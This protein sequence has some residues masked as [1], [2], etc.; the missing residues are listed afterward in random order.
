MVTSHRSA[1]D[2]ISLNSDPF[3]SHGHMHHVRRALISLWMISATLSGCIEDPPSLERDPAGMEISDQT[4]LAGGAEMSQGRDVEG[5]QSLIVDMATRDED[6]E[7]DR[8]RG[9]DEVIVDMASVSPDIDVI[10]LDLGVDAGSVVEEWPALD[11]PL[12]EAEEERCD[13]IDNDLDALIDEGVSNPCGG[14]APFDDEVGCVAWRAQLIQTQ[15]RVDGSSVEPSEE[16]VTGALDPQRLIMLSTSI[17]RFEEFTVEGARCTRYGAAQSWSGARSFGDVS[18]NTPQASLTLRPDPTQPGRYRALGEDEPFTLHLPQDEVNLSWSGWSNPQSA[19]PQP[20]I[21]PDELSLRSPELIRLADDDELRQIVEAFQRAEDPLAAPE[22][23]SLRWVAEPQGQE[24]G[25]PLTLYVG[26]SQSLRRAGAYQEIRHYLLSAQLFDDGRLDLDL[27]SSF[28]A[29]GSSIW[30]YLERAHQASAVQGPH[31]VTARAGHRA[32]LRSGAGGGAPN[33][34]VA[35]ELLTPGVDRPEP[36]VGAEGLT[37]RWRLIDAAAPPE[38]IVISLI[39]YDSLRTE[40]IA[41]RVDDPSV[42]TITLP[43]DRLNFWPQGPQS[44]RQ[45]TLRADTKS[46][47]LSYPDRGL[48][49]RSESLILRLSDLD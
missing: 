28:R 49:R 26:G 42:G 25:A 7:L 37:V 36:D 21:E 15:I 11:L 44:V 14:C 2:H 20:I 35:L 9:G 43:A 13:G 8:D 30:V 46:L 33:P 29:P 41:C 5:G 48:L 34:S 1:R 19:S 4:T 17:D 3:K 18:L 39:L 40:Q 45:L 12:P 31:P 16:A 32:E 6:Q 22:P 38:Q 27:P 24:A 47:E 10:D 23:I